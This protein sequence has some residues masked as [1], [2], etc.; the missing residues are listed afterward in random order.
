M[1]QFQNKTALITGASRGL[2]VNI[3]LT[4]AEHGCNIIA[5]SRN[6]EGLQSTCKK[7]TSKGVSA[8]YYP[9]DLSSTKSVRE[10]IEKILSENQSI[11]FLINNAGIENYQKFHH[12]EPNT[13]DDILATNLRAPM[14]IARLLL[15]NMLNRGGH[16]VNIAS[17]AGKKGISYNSIYSASKAG[18]IMWSDALRQELS[19][20][21][22]GV[23]VICP[24]YISDSG[25]FADAGIDAPKLLGTSPPQKVANAVVKSIIG[26]VPEIIVN[27]GPIKPL[28]SIGQLSPKLSDK[29]VKFFG[30]PALNLARVKLE[31]TDKAGR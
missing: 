29:I 14:E 17:L 9:I 19:N 23:S 22:V 6:E 13:I 12:Y 3:S 8:T 1:N 5:V 25:M 18:L 4:L 31:N 28:L 30:V 20:T 16:I 11:D 26:N 21:K 7:I 24:G 27:N 15:P 2:G 10:G